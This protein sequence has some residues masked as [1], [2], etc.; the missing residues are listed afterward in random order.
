MTIISTANEPSEFDFPLE[1]KKELTAFPPVSDAI[2]K[3]KSIDWEMVKIRALLVVNGIGAGLSIAGRS[4]Y[5]VGE[6][7]KKV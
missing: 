1:D 7:L 2:D 3:I 5:T 6:A 4:V